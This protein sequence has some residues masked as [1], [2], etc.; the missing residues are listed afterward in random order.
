MASYAAEASLRFVQSGTDP[1]QDHLAIAPAPDVAR[2]MRDCTVH[3]LDRV[4]GLER[5]RER[6]QPRSCTFAAVA[7]WFG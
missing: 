2:V 1:A 6:T 4:G 3:V 5:A 7:S